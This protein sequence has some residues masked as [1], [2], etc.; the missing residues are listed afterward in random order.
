M[1]TPKLRPSAPT[2]KMPV[3]PMPSRGFK[4]M[5]PCVAWKARMSASLRVT[6]V[7]AMNCGNSRIASFSG[8]LRSAAGLLK[9]LAPS[10]SAW[11]SRWVA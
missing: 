9:T 11:L 3:P 6:K 5:V 10:R 8:W 1:I 7:G 2:L 4:M